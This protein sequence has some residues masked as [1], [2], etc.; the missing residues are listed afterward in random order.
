MPLP[1]LRAVAIEATPRDATA[2]GPE[3]F[4]NIDEVVFRLGSER[5]NAIF[6]EAKAEAILARWQRE[7]IGASDAKAYAD[8]LREAAFSE[9]E[10]GVI[11]VKMIA[12][13]DE[14][15]PGALLMLAGVFDFLATL[16]GEG[17]ALQ[18]KDEEAGT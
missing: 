5:A 11:A 2:V 18:F 10:P 16:A 14:D 8:K 13:K 17:K 4:C 15:A 9:E 3:V 1:R 12:G 7:G 6:G